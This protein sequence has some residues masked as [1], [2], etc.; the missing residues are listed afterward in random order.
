MHVQLGIWEKEN[1]G[2]S[3]LGFADIFDP[4][5]SSLAS[6]TTNEAM[7]RTA[8]RSPKTELKSVSELGNY[9][10][11]TINRLTVLHSDLEKPTGS[12]RLT[13]GKKLQ[14]LKY[15]SQSV[16]EYGSPGHRKRNDQL[17]R[18]FDSADSSLPQVVEY[19]NSPL[20]IRDNYATQLEKGFGNKGKNSNSGI[21]INQRR[22]HET[23]RDRDYN[24]SVKPGPVPAKDGIRLNQLSFKIDQA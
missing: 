4:L 10:D 16:M 9:V 21:R 12:R 24:N 23:I 14:T 11:R 7:N 20:K 8:M 1:L 6:I 19:N 3:A 17:V 2:S 15:N 13:E 5:V 22:H 18:S